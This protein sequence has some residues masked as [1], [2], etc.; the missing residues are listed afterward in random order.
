MKWF[1][2]VFCLTVCLAAQGCAVE[3]EQENEAGNSVQK[4][5]VYDSRAVAVAFVGTRIFNDY[6][7]GLM[8]RHKQA[9]ADGDSA[10]VA[11]LEAEGQGRQEKIHRQSFGTDPVDDILEHIRDEMNEIAKQAGVV[12]IASKW[13]KEALAEYE[14]AER[15]DVTMDLVGKLRPNQRQLGFVKEI[16]K[17][18]PLE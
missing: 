16:M 12:A 17:K 7:E 9:K 5:G 6:L 4:L 18:Q 3:K 1:G 15:V 14:H 13:D 2:I 11:Q 8:A 10:K